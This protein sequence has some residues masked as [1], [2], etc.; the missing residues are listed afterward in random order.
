LGGLIKHSRPVGFFATRRYNVGNRQAN[1]NFHEVMN[2]IFGYLWANVLFKAFSWDL[3]DKKKLI[4]VRNF[5]LKSPTNLKPQLI[6]HLVAHQFGQIRMGLE[7]FGQI[8]QGTDANHGHFARETSE[9]SR[10]RLKMS[11]R[12][13][14]SGND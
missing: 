6:L 5:Q 13:L 3:R 9:V 10:R 4:Q 1:H 8:V 12:S 14:P 2:L 7:A 11:T